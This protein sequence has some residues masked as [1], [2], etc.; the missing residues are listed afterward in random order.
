MVA[1]EA[2]P[3]GQVEDTCPGCDE[4][5]G[6]PTLLTS[7]VR[8]YACARCNRSWQVVRDFQ[9]DRR[10]AMQWRPPSNRTSIV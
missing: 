6:T 10:A 5:C 2:P 1:F 8:Y 7:M 3:S 9:V 4:P